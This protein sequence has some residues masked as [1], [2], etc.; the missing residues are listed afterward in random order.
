MEDKMFKIN[1]VVQHL[2][3]RNREKN[4]KLCKQGRHHEQT[5]FDTGDAILALAFR[6]DEEIE[7]AYRMVLGG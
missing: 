3:K 5:M 1:V 4:K 6:S 7:R 2:D